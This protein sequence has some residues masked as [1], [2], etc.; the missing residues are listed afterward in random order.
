VAPPNELVPDGLKVKW[1]STAEQVADV[2]RGL[3]MQGELQPGD[4]LREVPLAASLG[5]SRNTVREAI[6]LLAHE[7][8]VTHRLH[9]GAVVAQLTPEAVVDIFRAR[10]V[11]ELAAV[12]ASGAAGEKQ[13]ERLAAAVDDLARAVSAGDWQ[14]IAE[15]DLSF[16]REIV[17]LLGSRRVDAFY[18]NIQ[19]EHR[20]AVSLID[21]A[22]VDPSPLV[23][24]HREIYDA[25]AAG[26]VGEAVRL[27]ASHLV[28]AEQR[29]LRLVR[30]A[31]LPLAQPRAAAPGKAVV[32]SQSP[33]EADA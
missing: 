4:R 16:H 27:L 32:S 19:S 29:L 24:E 15:G 3:M 26:K 13:L 8:V 2:L 12:E 33:A 7:G 20:I 31:S 25:I 14:G 22:Y 17:R 6:R 5:V 30:G 21:R 9:R 10:R 28:D 23:A 18:K 11:L 1:S